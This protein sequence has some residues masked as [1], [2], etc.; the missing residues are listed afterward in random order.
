MPTKRA[1][2]AAAPLPPATEQAQ[3]TPLPVIHPLSS[4]E[5]QEFLAWY[6][7]QPVH[8]IKNTA[9]VFRSLPA[10]L[11]GLVQRVRYN[12][13]FDDTVVSI[14]LNDV[15][16]KC[17]QWENSDNPEAAAY[18]MLRSILLVAEQVHAEH[19][20]LMTRAKMEKSYEAIRESMEGYYNHW[21]EH[22]R[23]FNELD[24]VEKVASAAG[25]AAFVIRCEDES[26]HISFSMCFDA[27]N[28]TRSGIKLT[29][30]NV[31]AYIRQHPEM[32]LP[33]ADALIKRG[34]G[35]T[36][37]DFHSV[38]EHMRETADAPALGEGWL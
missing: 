25:I 19:P 4:G 15:R 31:D 1:L 12:K 22:P 26:D 21:Q 3:E 13:V 38:L 24:T 14:A 6:A 30:K 18:Q 29:N 27:G 33:I 8:R 35:T 34:L 7:P 28:R 16:T 10:E 2:E 11:R 37:E 17:V 5:T 9:E 20:H 36:D 32:G 23:V